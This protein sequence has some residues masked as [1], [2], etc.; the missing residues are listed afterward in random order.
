MFSEQ[1]KMQFIY[2]PA[3]IVTLILLFS[4]CIPTFRYN[5][6]NKALN[7]ALKFS[8]E[9]FTKRNYSQALSFVTSDTV[10]DDSKLG[11]LIASMH[12]SGIYPKEMKAEAYEVLPG[13]NNIRIY[14]YGLTDNQE[15]YYYCIVT[16][17][18]GNNY[19][20]KEIYR[21]KDNSP[22]PKMPLTKSF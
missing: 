4:A 10:F 17:Q 11:E 6:P 13:T 7:I 22:Y 16:K 8:D 2:F 12:P 1:S 20:V 15:K 14:L 9:A 5:D 3:V 19:K 21:N 18:E